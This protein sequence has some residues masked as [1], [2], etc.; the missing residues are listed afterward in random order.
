MSIKDELRARENAAENLANEACLDK[1]DI[2]DIRRFSDGSHLPLFARLRRECPIHFCVDSPFGSYWSIT[3]AEDIQAINADHHRFSSDHNVIIGDIPKNFRFP[4]FMVSDP[5]EHS[6]WRK[7]VSPAFSQARLADLAG[8]CRTHISKLLDGLPMWEPFDWVQQISAE[9]TPWMI[10][11]LFD[12][13][14]EDAAALIYW[15]NQLMDIEA[16]D[17]THPRHQGRQEQLKMFESF[18]HEVSRERQ[19]SPK[20][21]DIL[22]QLVGGPYAS[23]ML[24]DMAHFMGTVSLVVGAGETTRSAASAI[25]VAMNQ[26]PE[27][28][29]RLLKEPSLV[30]NAVQE[31]I[32]WQTPLAHMRR[33]AV[34]D[35]DIQGARIQRGDRVVLW[36]CSGNRDEELFPKGE[37]LD[38]RRANARKHL[39]YGYGIHR[40]IGRHAA[41]MQLRL[42][43]EEMVSRFSCV[44]LLKA[45]IRTESNYFAGYDEMMVRLA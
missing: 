31:I 7:A 19:N 9:L 23:E 20:G 4:A 33:T 21:S 24:G 39:S 17:V 11:A 14:Q 43:L 2:S 15:S 3:R 40:C 13:E 44:E 16:E 35:V 26:Y 32:R 10:A 1:L 5:P 45:P 6:K 42:L 18:L 28:W 22:S 41:E 29:Q 36:Y 8:P 25:V 12:L 37:A 30:G 38:I 34:E 27:E